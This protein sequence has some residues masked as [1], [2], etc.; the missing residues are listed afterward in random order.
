MRRMKRVD[1]VRFGTAMALFASP[2]GAQAVTVTNPGAVVDRQ[3]AAYNRHDLDGFL[4]TY[5]DKVSFYTLGSAKIVHTKAAAHDVIGSMF[6]MYPNIQSKTLARVGFGSFV[7]DREQLSGL[8]NRAPLTILSVYEV[9]Y[10]HI[11]NYWQSPVTKPNASDAPAQEPDPAARATVDQL[12]TAFNKHDLDAAIAEFADTVAHY[13]LT[14]DTVSESLTRDDVRDRLSR[15]FD[16]GRRPHVVARAQLA[17]G[18]YVVAR[19]TVDGLPADQPA[20]DLVIAQ[21]ENGKIV[22]LWEAS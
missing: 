7:V 4:D 17:V 11:V 9:R 13:A 18:P 1:L 8:P 15:L 20:G 12:R 14:R 22:A 19:E 6:S 10:G 21:V 5:A 3:V 2:V 16:Q